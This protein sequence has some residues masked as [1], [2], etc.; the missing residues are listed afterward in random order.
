MPRQFSVSRESRYVRTKMLQVRDSA[1]NLTNSYV[2][3]VWKPFEFR[4]TDGDVFYRIADHEVGR[5]DLLSHRFYGTPSFWWVIAYVN[6]VVDPI[7][8]LIPGMVLR[9]PPLAHVQAVVYGQAIPFQE[10]EA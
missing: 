6:N 5:L 10:A 9:I 8:D 7:F 3:G 4:A 2:W 1:D